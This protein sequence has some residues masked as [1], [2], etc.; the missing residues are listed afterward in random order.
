[1]QNIKLIHTIPTKIVGNI[2]GLMS[3]ER[4]GKKYQKNK[5]KNEEEIQ[6]VML[7]I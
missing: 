5:R 1:M 4:S 2:N 7:R 6:Y 3:Y